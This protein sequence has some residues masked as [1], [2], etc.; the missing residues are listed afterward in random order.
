MSFCLFNDCGMLVEMFERN[1]FVMLID[2]ARRN[3]IIYKA[4]NTRMLFV[5]GNGNMKRYFNQSISYTD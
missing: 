1:I 3:C 5:N 4:G 2:L